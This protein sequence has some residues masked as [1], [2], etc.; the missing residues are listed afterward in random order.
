[1][2]EPKRGILL[3]KPALGCSYRVNRRAISVSTAPRVLAVQ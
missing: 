3:H 2:M 1:M